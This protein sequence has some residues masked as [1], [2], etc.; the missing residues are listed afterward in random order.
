MKQEETLLKE[1]FMKGLRQISHVWFYKVNDRVA[2]GVPD[3]VIC[4]KGAFVACE[5]KYST[6]RTAM[7]KYTMNKIKESWGVVHVV[8][9]ENIDNVLKMIKT[10]AEE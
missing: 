3:I 1:K 8:T 4:C 2:V 10:M 7:Q 5:L 9:P 6:D